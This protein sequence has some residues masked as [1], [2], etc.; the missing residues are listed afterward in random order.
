[1]LPVLSEFPVKKASGVQVVVA[2]KEPG[3]AM[4][5]VGSLLGDDADHARSLPAAREKALLDLEFRDGVDLNEGPRSAVEML[6]ERNSVEYVRRGTHSRPGYGRRRLA[7]TVS[8]LRDAG[9]RIA[10]L[11]AGLNP[12]QLQEPSSVQRQLLDHLLADHRA[13]L[14]GSPVDHRRLGRDQHRI[15]DFTHLKGQGMIHDGE[16]LELDPFHHRLLEAGHFHTQG[17]RAHRQGG[18]IEDP[19]IV[20]DADPSEARRLVDHVKVGP[21]N[22]RAAVVQHPA[23]DGP[24]PFRLSPET[25]GRCQY[26]GDQHEYCH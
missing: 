23:G 14:G 15:A 25:A 17:V 11:H 3:A 13:Q 22:H 6:L 12:G 8:P 10:G 24:G 20:G 1:M 21:W 18:E 4:D 19:L 26:D 16:H 5:L 7:R 2:V 9:S